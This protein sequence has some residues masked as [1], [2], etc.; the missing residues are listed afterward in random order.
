MEGLCRARA[1]DLA[2]AGR[3]LANIRERLR[4][5]GVIRAYGFEAMR[6]E[7]VAD[8]VRQDEITVGEPL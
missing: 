7:V 4:E 1:V 8:G 5:F 6:C 3:A 2:Q